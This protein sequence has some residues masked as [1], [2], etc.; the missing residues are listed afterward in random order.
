MDFAQAFVVGQGEDVGLV[1]GKVLFVGG[2]P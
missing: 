1:F 2:D